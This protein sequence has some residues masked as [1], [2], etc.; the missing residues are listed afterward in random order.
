MPRGRKLWATPEQ[1]KWLQEKLDSFIDHQKARKTHT[2]WPKMERE[3]FD[4]FPI[5]SRTVPTPS[6]SESD[7][8]SGGDATL[9][10][11]DVKVE[12]KVPLEGLV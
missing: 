3:W 1:A 12:K 10:G 4:K 2:F 8:E 6:D 9:P 5:E 11:F 7:D